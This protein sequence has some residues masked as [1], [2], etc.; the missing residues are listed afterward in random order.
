MK[1]RPYQQQILNKFSNLIK[2]GEKNGLLILA[3]GGGK[4]LIAMMALKEHFLDH[5]K[6]VLWVAHR[7]ELLNQAINTLKKVSPN[8]SYSLFNSQ[9]KDVSGQIIFMSVQSFN[10]NNAIN[11]DCLTI[12]ETHHE[13]AASYQYLMENIT[14][15]FKLGLTAC[16]IRLDEKIIDY[17]NIIDNI[18]IAKLIELGYAPNI[19]LKIVD[20]TNTDALYNYCGKKTIFFVSS[21]T[22]SKINLKYIYVDST[23]SCV[24]ENDKVYSIKREN[25]LAFDPDIIVNKEI[26][27]EGFDWPVCDTVIINRPTES[28]NNL[29]QMIGRGLRLSPGAT[30]IEDSEKKECTV[31]IPKTFLPILLQ[32]LM[33]ILEGSINFYKH[34]E[35][36]KESIIKAKKEV[37]K[38]ISTKNKT[39][40]INSY[41]Y[42]FLSKQEEKYSIIYNTDSKEF[43]YDLIS[44]IKNIDFNK[45]SYTY[46]YKLKSILEYQLLVNS[47][48]LELLIN[49]IKNNNIYIFD[50]NQSNNIQKIDIN[51]L[52]TVFSEEEFFDRYTYIFKGINYEYIGNKAIFMLNDFVFSKEKKTLKFAEE[53]NFG[54][55]WSFFFDLNTLSNNKIHFYKLKNSLTNKLKILTKRKELFVNF[56][57]P[58]EKN[59]LEDVLLSI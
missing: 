41:Q 8:T 56:L 58:I 52:N 23:T 33:I 53:S 42:L 46:V 19:K 50:L 48:E 16:P 34:E 28:L 35:L 54:K 37:S 10:P 55:N 7:D 5:D 1:L 22:N 14:Y 4:T 6:K 59:K 49:N 32:N 20:S 17:E 31:V 29:M 51:L 12:D 27:I 45:Y 39:N 2:S 43:T 11:V 9:E 47:N 25:I 57:Y 44:Y 38:L 13:S 26:F 40:I 36:Q 30:S 24:V 18:S 15:N 21:F 3:T